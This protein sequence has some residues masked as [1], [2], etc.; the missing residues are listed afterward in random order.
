[1]SNRA[2]TGE[3]D[4]SAAVFFVG[5]SLT[6]AAGLFG[7][8]AVKRFIRSRKPEEVSHQE[9]SFGCHCEACAMNKRWLGGNKEKKS[10]GKPSSTATIVM[11]AI[12]AVCAVLAAGTFTG[13][14]G[15]G[16]NATNS[17]EVWDPYEILGIKIGATDADIKAAYRKLSLKYHPDRNI[18]NPDAADKFIRITKAYEAL[19]NELVRANYEK[20]GNP[21][22]PVSVKVGIAL[23]SWLMDSKNS[24]L[25]LVF[26]LL[27]FIVLVPAISLFVIR[28][29]K[30]NEK[31]EVLPETMGAFF[32]NIKDR[33]KPKDVLEWLSVAKEFEPLGPKS[34]EDMQAVMEVVKIVLP[35]KIQ[36]HFKNPFIIKSCVLLYAHLGH[37]D[38]KL[39]QDFFMDTMR[40]VKKLPE[41]I[42]AFCAI[43]QIKEYLQPALSA[44]RLLP[45]LRQGTWDSHP[46][47]QLPYFDK[48]TCE[49]AG[50]KKHGGVATISRLVMMSDQDRRKFLEGL[51]F[52]EVMI[53]DVCRVIR[54]V[55]APRLIVDAKMGVEDALGSD[56]ITEGSI[57]TVTVRTHFELKGE[58][59]EEEKPAKDASTVRVVKVKVA[60]KKEKKV[61]PTKVT[62][63]EVMQDPKVQKALR[64]LENDFKGTNSRAKKE[65]EKKKQSVISRAIAEAQKKRDEE[66][67]KEK[68]AKEAEEAAK[69]AEEDAKKESEEKA[70]PI[71]EEQV[72]TTSCSAADDEDA[73]ENEKDEEEED[74]DEDSDYDILDKQEEIRAARKK[75][76]A[77]EEAKSAEEK[78]AAEAA[79][80]IQ[81]EL[82]G[83][84]YVHAPFFP[85]PHAEKWYFVIGDDH[86][87]VYAMTKGNCPTIST[88]SESKI[89]IKFQAPEKAGKYHMTLYVMSDSY[90]GREVQQNLTMVVAPRKEI[91]VEEEPIS[92][93]EDDDDIDDD[94]DEEEE[95]KSNEEDNDDDDNDDDDDDDD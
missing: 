19:T 45:M 72:V 85:E 47:M 62:R 58:E 54:K 88:D 69:K 10:N 51:E 80:A 60:E 31:A 9:E 21:D 48:K 14:L 16:V 28:R 12:A 95:E 29:W 78:K 66:L 13:F 3:F 6:I 35:E 94:E 26:Y 39:T 4:D 23:P 75:R 44:I 57:V 89:T 67:A 79:D 32:H 41:I 8:F 81:Q 87:K 93:D 53:D 15:V 73:K 27:G 37:L 56:E 24:N 71:E 18:G 91:P 74:D 25:V 86:N 61:D 36:C 55:F 7:F 64:D 70:E 33:M 90:I 59:A 65:L 17:S 1:M 11:A 34:N 22:G 76:E 50:K 43:S 82:R 20:Y 52:N 49:A 5:G 77:E 84:V 30:K 40:M 68:A 92:D 2:P 46:L 63:E 42:D 38:D 83:P